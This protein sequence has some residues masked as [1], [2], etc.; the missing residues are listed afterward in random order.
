MGIDPVPVVKPKSD[1]AVLLNFKD[2]QPLAQGVN[3]PGRQEDAISFSRREGGKA[4][5]NRALPQCLAKRVRSDAGPQPRIDS[6][7][8]LGMEDH[9]GF[10]LAALA[11][12]KQV[13][14]P[15][16]RVDLDRKGFPRIEEL[17]QQGKPPVPIRYGPEQLDG[18]F[19]HELAQG[20]APQRP[21][22]HTAKV[23]ALV[24]E[25]P[26]F[27]DRLLARQPPA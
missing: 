5:G 20:T 9:P 15:I 10:G 17:Q 16:I 7:G 24:A 21:V 1:V 3:G 6:A 11:R 25:D 4:I 19:F 22:G 23:F 2:E 12:G 26:G 27:A 8:R 18:G 14:V 13:G